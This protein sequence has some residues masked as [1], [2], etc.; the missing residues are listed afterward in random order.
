MMITKLNDVGISRFSEYLQL[1]KTRPMEPIPLVLLDDPE[2]SVPLGIDT[3]FDG[4]KTFQSRHECGKY[5]AK[6][7]QNAETRYI[8][9]DAGLWSSLGLIWFDQL[10]PADKRGHRKPRRKDNYIL[11]SN[12]RHV[13]RHAI[14]TAWRLAATYEDNASFLQSSDMK[15]RGELVE[16]LLATDY[17]INC[18]GVMLT[19]SQLYSDRKTGSFKKGSGNKDSGGVRRYVAWLKQIRQT[20]D[21][22][23]MS[24]DDLIKILPVEFERFK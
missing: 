21:L 10:C 15:T 16:Q 9:D 11:S 22:F 23:S 2:T 5:V 20:Y 7:L 1:L 8:L 14:K 6:A 3:E 18:E 17:Y 4:T 13:M 24:H 19:A 12:P